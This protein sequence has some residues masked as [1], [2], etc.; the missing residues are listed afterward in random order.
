MINENYQGEINSFK[1]N[2]NIYVN[3]KIVLYGIGRYTAVLIPAIP[4]YNIIGLMDRDK[5][6]IGKHMYGLPI[7][8]KEQVKKEAD[9]II[10]NTSENYWEN[11]FHRIKMLLKNITFLFWPLG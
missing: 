8:S 1:K 4:E 2:F 10:I 7:L 11:I 9:L 6:N 5:E 3:K